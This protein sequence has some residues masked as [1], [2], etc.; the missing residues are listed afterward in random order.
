MSHQEQLKV[1]IP[2]GSDKGQSTT[3]PSYFPTQ[4]ANATENLTMTELAIDCCRLLEIIRNPGK[5]S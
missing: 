4:E 2:H 5:I 3:D 1:R